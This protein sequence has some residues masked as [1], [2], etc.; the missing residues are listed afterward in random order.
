MTVHDKVSLL[1]LTLLLIVALLLILALLLI[2]LFGSLLYSF[3]FFVIGYFHWSSYG[4]TFEAIASGSPVGRVTSN[5]ALRSRLV[6][7]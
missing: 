4:G 1:I 5:W 2:S 3:V 6:F 7:A